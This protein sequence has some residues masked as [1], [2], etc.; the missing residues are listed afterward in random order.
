MLLD[1]VAAQ[2]EARLDKPGDPRVGM[3][4]GSYGG[5]IQ[6]VLATLDRRVDAIV[7]T[8][9]WHSLSTSLYKEQ[10]VKSGW[11]GLLFASAANRNLD[12][13]IKSAYDQG[14]A[15]GA[16]TADNI[17]WF[18]DRGPADLV[19]KITAPTMLVQ[20]TV[21]TLFTLDEAVTNYRLLRRHRVPVKMLWYCGGHGVCL[22]DPGS[23]TRVPDATIAWLDRYV[24]GET[25]VGTG[26]RF[27]WIDQHGREFTARDY[28]PRPNGRL[29]ARGRGVLSLVKEGGAG[30]VKPRAGSDLIATASTG[31]APA[32]AANAVN[33]RLPRARRAASIVGAP[34]VRLTYRGTAG[35]GDR[36]TRV[37]AQLVDEA[38]GDVLGNQIVPI[39][40]TL[41]GRRHTV[42]RNLELVAHTLRR[43]ERVTL[44]LV[45]T[46]VAYA[47]PRL[48][49][50]VRFDDVRLTL[51]LVR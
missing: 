38:T 34:R 21:D 51:P 20:G 35:P 4:G 23:A 8:I 19:S 36:P 18:R 30:P 17:Q 22:S 3:V 7:P 42:A 16:L 24:K 50:R 47:E 33:V 14:V 13:H 31:I 27:D 28:P 25:S 1:W 40:V 5:G 37:F 12:P 26:P 29:V 46:T 32:R 6:L 9:A 41:D 48:G 43:G 2:T 11:A 44:Q 39:A 49:G 45:A 15:A 10:I